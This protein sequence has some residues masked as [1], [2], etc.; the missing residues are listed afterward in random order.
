MTQLIKFRIIRNVPLGN[1][2]ENF[3]LVQ[4]GGSIVQRTAE[5]HRQTDENQHVHLRCLPRNAQQLLLCAVEQ[6]I[7]QEQ[8]PAGIARQ[9]QLRKADDPYA[10]FICLAAQREN[11]V[12]IECAV[13][14][15]DFRRGRRD[16]DKSIFHSRMHLRTF[17]L[18]LL[19]YPRY[20]RLKICNYTQTLR[21]SAVFSAGHTESPAPS[22]YRRNRRCAAAF[23]HKTGT[24]H[25]YQDK[26]VSCIPIVIFRLR[27]A[28]F[29]FTGCGKKQ[30]CAQWHIPANDL[31]YS[32]SA[33]LSVWSSMSSVSLSEESE[34]SGISGGVF[35]FTSK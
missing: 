32:L 10:L 13:R 23:S 8:I 22:A 31:R 17:L 14:H 12:R 7:V 1:H 9:A 28:L 4:E 26:Y 34:T 30:G 27:P 24:L 20:A 2:A 18:M 25:S 5:P 33:S 15:V 6:N 19:L 3:A 16:L 35:S 29:L 11:I 21:I